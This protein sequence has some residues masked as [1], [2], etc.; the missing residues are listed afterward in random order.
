VRRLCIRGTAGQTWPALDHP[1]G[2]K[3]LAT[4]R[5]P[6]PL[7]FPTAPPDADAPPRWKAATA[8]PVVARNSLRLIIAVVSLLG[9]T[10]TPC[11]RID[12][13]CVP[14]DTTSLDPQ[15]IRGP[16]ARPSI[17]PGLKSAEPSSTGLPDTRISTI[18]G[19]WIGD[20]RWNEA[21]APMIDRVESANGPIASPRRT[22]GNQKSAPAR[23]IPLPRRNDSNRRNLWNYRHLT[24]LPC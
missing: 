23:P 19:F 11:R 20:F 2:K 6:S 17:R 18:Q 3:S 13:L 12:D 8:A 24:L 1:P 21:V 16:L 7:L 9:K 22:L 14:S 15:R 4:S 5:P 10:G